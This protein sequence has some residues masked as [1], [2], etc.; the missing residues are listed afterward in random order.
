MCQALYQPT[1]GTAEIRGRMPP[2]PA[3]GCW[4]G[5]AL[6]FCVQRQGPLPCLLRGAFR[7]PPGLAHLPSHFSFSILHLKIEA[8]VL[9]LMVSP[10]YTCHACRFT[11]LSPMFTQKPFKNHRIP[12]RTLLS[13]FTDKE[14]GS[15]RSSDVPGVTQQVRH[16]QHRGARTPDHPASSL[17]PLSPDGEDQSPL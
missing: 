15:E 7:P 10:S 8:S 11:V 16:W 2:S 3:P 4:H 14:I 6:Q 9:S 17:L 12:K 13:H 5:R 1:G